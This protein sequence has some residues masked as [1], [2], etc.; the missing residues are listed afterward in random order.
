M[1][2]VMVRATLISQRFHFERNSRFSCKYKYTKSLVFIQVQ[3]YERSG[4]CHGTI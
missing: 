1:P 4:K 3:V 2:V